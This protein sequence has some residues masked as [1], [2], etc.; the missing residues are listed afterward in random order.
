[1]S[2]T[3]QRPAGPPVPP[4]TPQELEREVKQAR[5]E[6]ADAVDSLTTRLSPSYQANQ[7]ARNTK[8]ASVD[9]RGLF[10][11]DGLPA[12]E[13]R[14]R[15]AKILLGAAAAGVVAAALVVVSIVRC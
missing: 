2:A 12:D 4:P 3:N 15:N 14:A 5:R 1:M 8:Q 11:G 6:L 10:T 7:L 9:A 13:R